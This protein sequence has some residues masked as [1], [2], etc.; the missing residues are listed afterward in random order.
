MDWALL[1]TVD[2]GGAEGVVSA[3]TLTTAEV[4][5]EVEGG[6]EF[7]RTGAEIEDFT[8]PAVIVVGLT[9][10]VAGLEGEV[11]NWLATVATG[12]EGGLPGAEEG[13]GFTEVVEGGRGLLGMAEIVSAEGVFPE[14]AVEGVEAALDLGRV[15]TV[16]DG[17][18]LG[19][20]DFA[21]VTT[22]RGG[23]LLGTV[24]TDLA[25]EGLPETATEGGGGLVGMVVVDELATGGGGAFPDEDLA[26]AAVAGG[27]GLVGMVAVDLA[28]VATIGGG[29][30]LGIEVVDL[31]VLEGG[32]GGL[33]LAV[34]PA[35]LEVV[36][37]EGGGGLLGIVTVDFTTLLELD[38][39]R[40]DVPFLAGTAA[41]VVVVGGALL[42]TASDRVRMC[43]ISYSH[44]TRENKM[45]SEKFPPCTCMYSCASIAITHTHTQ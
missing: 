17:G 35:D 6:E 30:L 21:L 32:G 1:V 9:E 44:M 45:S 16:G 19:I 39:I 43:S 31:G 33:L 8:V 7:F 40:V 27:G 22:A 13:S 23:G 18:L 11:D 25:E 29:G 24:E 4:D 36:A 34:G 41:V 20:V 2:V 3:G 37:V 12:L 38:L 14:A 15:T 26:F 5:E 28:F 42:V 10:A